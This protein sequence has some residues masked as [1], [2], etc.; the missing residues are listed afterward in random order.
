MNFTSVRLTFMHH[1]IPPHNRN[2]PAPQQYAGWHFV[3]MMDRI[4]E[5]NRPNFGQ[6]T[7]ETSNI[8]RIKT[9]Q[10]SVYFPYPSGPLTVMSVEALSKLIIHRKFH[11]NSCKQ[12][13]SL[14]NSLEF[15]WVKIF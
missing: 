7:G 11:G 13:I 2:H 15:S 5:Y 3:D 10:P 14:P 12:F 8:M 6:A 1:R 9:A 4:A